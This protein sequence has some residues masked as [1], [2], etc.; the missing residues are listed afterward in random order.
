[1]R[2]AMPP[3]KQSGQHGGAHKLAFGKCMVARL[4]DLHGLR[5]GKESPGK[6]AKRQQVEELIQ[7]KLGSIQE[8]YVP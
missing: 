1:M 4:Q 6:T 3:A 7:A 2:P 5:I 8:H